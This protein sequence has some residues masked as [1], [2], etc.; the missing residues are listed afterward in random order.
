MLIPDS[1][2]IFCL[3]GSL[4]SLLD[5][6]LILDGSTVSQPQFDNLKS[7]VKSFVS[8]LDVSK[9]KD[10]VGIIE[11]GNRARILLP[12]EWL[13]SVQTV[14]DFI[15]TIRPSGGAPRLDRALAKTKDL[16]T[17]EQGSRPGVSK[18]AVL[19]ANSRYGGQANDLQQAVQKLK[20]DGVRLYVISSNAPDENNLQTLVRKDDIT[21]L[22]RFLGAD[23]KVSQLVKYIRDE[24][25]GRKLEL[26]QS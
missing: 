3:L 1:H 18:V 14:N 20:R 7:L 6:A 9:D 22:S 8:S 4:G 11:Y 17:I 13:N 26:I 12:F 21:R 23:A 10:H 24:N 2:S 19:V 25:K 5:I 15:D 16:F